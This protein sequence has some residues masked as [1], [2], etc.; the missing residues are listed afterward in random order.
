M[1]SED[2]L[3]ITRFA[4]HSQRAPCFPA[5]SA[6]TGHSYKERGAADGM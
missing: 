5:P 1:G 2:S 6:V 4:A 3:N